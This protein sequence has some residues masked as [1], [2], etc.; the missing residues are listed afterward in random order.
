[1]KMRTEIKAP[2]A[3]Q[4]GCVCE[5]TT[6]KRVW[7]KD[8]RQCPGIKFQRYAI[9]NE[10][11]LE[12][13]IEEFPRNGKLPS[14]LRRWRELIADGKIIIPADPSWTGFNT[15]SYTTQDDANFLGFVNWEIYPGS[16]QALGK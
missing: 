3:L 10:A 8:D 13:F 16:L 15:Y 6:L 7:L 11:D 4:V 12:A 2:E 9:E 5:V 1:M 14:V